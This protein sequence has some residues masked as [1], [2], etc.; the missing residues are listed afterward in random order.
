MIRLV[1]FDSATFERFLERSV[2]AYADD[3]VRAGRWTAGEALSEAQ[4]QIEGLLPQGASTPNHFFYTIL[5][6]SP[7]G[8]VGSIWLAIEPRGAFVYDLQIEEA[9]RRHGY[10]EAGLW[11]VERIAVDHGATKISL[12]VFGDNHGARRLYDRLG[13]VETNV[14]MS[15]PLSPPLPP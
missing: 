13:Y 1:P 15:K 6:G 8:P 5:A 4:K 2:P 3:N 10:A 14:M 7:A 12:H 9:H 11:E